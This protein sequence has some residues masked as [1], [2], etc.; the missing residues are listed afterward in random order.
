M[1]LSFC[2]VS[3]VVVPSGGRMLFLIV[4]RSVCLRSLRVAVSNSSLLVIGIFKF[5]CGYHLTVSAMRT[6]PVL[7]MNIL[8]QR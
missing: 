4:D 7:G 1:S 3:R 2:S 5:P 8:K 6:L